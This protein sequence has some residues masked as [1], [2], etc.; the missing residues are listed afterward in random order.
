MKK[1]VAVIF[2]GRSVEHDVSIITAYN[3]II[4]SLNL[5]E[6]F[7]VLPIYISKDGSWFSEKSMNNIDFFKQRDF[8]KK[9][10]SKIRLSFDGGLTIIWPG[11]K[12][13]KTKVDLVFP[14]MHGTFGEDGSLMG[15][16][17][18]ANVPFVGCDISSSVISMDKVLTKQILSISG[19][20]TVPYIYFTNKEWDLR[21]DSIIKD[22]NIKYP[23]FVKP[24]HLGSSIGIAK[25][26]REVDL[27]NA[28]EVAF[29]YDDKVLVEESIENLIELTVPVMGNDNL[30]LGAIERPLNREDFFSFNDK[31]LRKNNLNY[32]EIPAK[33]DHEL[34]EKTKNLAKQ[35]YKAIGCSGIARIDFL[36]NSKKEIY[37]NEINTLPGSLYSH[38]WRKIGISN[39]DLVTKL[40]E[41]AEQ[42]FNERKEI[43]YT[44]NSNILKNFGGQ[45]K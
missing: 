24:A 34:S 30:T 13:K 19:I 21:K 20:S 14:A 33:I 26:N 44:F 5:T 43:R 31:Y 10:K 12:N 45:K 35:S 3:P 16:I 9:L 36:S 17:R 2:G 6:K 25:V 42:K 1:T 11:L 28:I 39:V 27:Q 22:I 15:L 23:L 29:H 8:G 40:I 37:V 32:S 41:L 7:N 4:P 18:M 38:N